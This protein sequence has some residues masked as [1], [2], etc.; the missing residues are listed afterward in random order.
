[1]RK[2]VI[3]FAVGALM[4][5]IT[6]APA[7]AATESPS[8]PGLSWSFDGPFGTFDRGALQRG[9]QVYKEVCAACHAMKLL[10]YRNLADPGGPGFSAAEVKA[11]AAE[12]EVTDGPNDDGEMFERPGLPSDR[13]KSPFPN[14]KAARVANNGSLPP[15]LS[16]IAKARKGG[17]DYLHAILSGYEDPPSGFQLADGMQYNKYFPGHQIAMAA[18]L[19][20]DRVEYADGTKATVDQMARDVS[21]FLMWTAEPKLEDR[22]RLGLKVVLFLLLLTGLFYAAKRKVWADLH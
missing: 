14:D 2:I 13:F 15:D 8:P 10:A 9:F 18:P 5:G 12:V 6:A 16:L 3:G 22:K 1:M 7:A 17:P 11:I 20:D 4:T 19:S 21:E